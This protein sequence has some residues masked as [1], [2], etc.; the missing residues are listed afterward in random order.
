M[1]ENKMH[2]PYYVFKIFDADEAVCYLANRIIQTYEASGSGIPDSMWPY[3]FCTKKYNDSIVD[4]IE[5]LVRHEIDRP[6]IS[7]QQAWAVYFMDKDESAENVKKFYQE[8]CAYVIDLEAVNAIHMGYYIVGAVAELI[9]SQG[10]KSVLDYGGGVGYDVVSLVKLGYDVSYY[11]L[12]PSYTF[13]Y[14]MGVF[15]RQKV[16]RQVE[17]SGILQECDGKLV[18]DRQYDVVWCREVLEHLWDVPSTVNVIYDLLKP[19]GLLALT[20]SFTGDDD[21]P[22]HLKKNVVYERTL[23]SFLKRHGFGPLMR[24]TPPLYFTRK[25]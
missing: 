24:Y 22:S 10:C 11:D 4:S 9:A 18:I 15:H 20:A 12:F 2:H 5:G 23:G 16:F 6:G 3:G 25:R 21:N 8:T 19:G 13:D 1:P 7:V 14:A 17:E